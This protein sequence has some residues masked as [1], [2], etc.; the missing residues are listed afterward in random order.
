MEGTHVDR[1]TCTGTHVRRHG[2]TL[3]GSIFRQRLGNVPTEKDA[4]HLQ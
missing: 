4:P 1:L 3:E 2:V